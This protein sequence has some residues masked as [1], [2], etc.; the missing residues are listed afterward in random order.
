[1]PWTG[2]SA[3]Y[4]KGTF[5]LPS[6]EK[7]DRGKSPC[8]GPAGLDRPKQVGVRFINSKPILG[9]TAADRL[10]DFRTR[11][12]RCVYQIACGSLD[13]R[14][15]LA[16]SIAEPLRHLY[17]VRRQGTRP[18][19][20]HY[21][22]LDLGGAVLLDAA[23]PYPSDLSGGQVRDAWLSQRAGLALGA[24]GLVADE[25]FQGSTYRDQATALLC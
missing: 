3:K 2:V 8:F 25:L 24:Y 1:V 23:G 13:P 10:F 21:A 17:I 4:R 19:G 7:R 5:P 20:F 18:H 22:L 6:S 14:R 15:R 9:R 12:W 11:C 16:R